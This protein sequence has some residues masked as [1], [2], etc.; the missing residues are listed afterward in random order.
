V[1]AATPRQALA[2]A[3]AHGGLHRAQGVA[4]LARSTTSLD[5]RLLATAAPNDR[6]VAYSPPA[7]RAARALASI[8]LCDSHIFKIPIIVVIL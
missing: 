5:N 8:E 4:T 1:L 6:L 2:A 3:R 7:L